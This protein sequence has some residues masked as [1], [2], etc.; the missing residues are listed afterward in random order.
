MTA[1]VSTRTFSGEHQFALVFYSAGSPE[2]NSNG[3]RATWECPRLPPTHCP[4]ASG[5]S[6]QHVK[7][8]LLR[9]MS[10]RDGPSWEPSVTH[11]PQGPTPGDHIGIP[12]APGWPAAAAIDVCAVFTDV[13]QRKRHCFCLSAA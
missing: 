1:K 12:Q 5:L 4:Q 3:D 11:S 10:A 13:G 6:S 7:S 2:E 8:Q 9:P